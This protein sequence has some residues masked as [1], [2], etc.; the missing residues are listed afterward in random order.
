FGVSLV[1]PILE[2]NEDSIPAHPELLEEMAKAFIESDFDLKLLIRSIV[3]T[4]AY[5]RASVAIS[6]ASQLEIQMFAKVPVR[7]MMPEQLF[8]SV[9]AATDIRDGDAGDANRPI[10]RRGRQQDGQ[11]AQFL[12]L[13]TSPDKAIETQTS[14]LQA[15][16][17]MNG[18]F[19]SERSRR[20]LQTIAVQN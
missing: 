19:V 10:G 9:C 2:P 1:E 3:L 11:R 6:E 5:Q 20:V 7:G 14:I 17:F 15:L 13:F 12:A 8:D 4:D 16:Y 18:T